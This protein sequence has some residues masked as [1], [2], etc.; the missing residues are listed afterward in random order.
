MLKSLQDNSLLPIIADKMLK[1]GVGFK[2]LSSYDRWFGVKY[3]KDKPVVED[4]F[5]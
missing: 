5:R 4:C 1:D 2:V 3:K